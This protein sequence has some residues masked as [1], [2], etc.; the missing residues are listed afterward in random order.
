MEQ[1]NLEKF[2]SLV[3]SYYICLKKYIV[4]SNNNKIILEDYENYAWGKNSDLSS[5][6]EKPSP[7]PIKNLEVTYQEKECMFLI[8]L[9]L[10]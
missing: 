2:N 10:K 9:T 3:D 8:T 6:F 5:L 1:T 7:F 4:S